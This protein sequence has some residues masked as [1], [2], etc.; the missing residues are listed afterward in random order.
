[1]T[2]SRFTVTCSF[3]AWFPADREHPERR[4]FI[5]PGSK[6]LFTDEAEPSGL[7]IK[8]LKSGYWYEAE[9]DEFLRATAAL[10]GRRGA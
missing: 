8:F 2:L 3:P 5:A 7:F 9:R 10:S 6:N 1:M 4:I